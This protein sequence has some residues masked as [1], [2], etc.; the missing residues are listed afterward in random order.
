MNDTQREFLMWWLINYGTAPVDFYAIRDEYVGSSRILAVPPPDLFGDV[1]SK[2]FFKRR[3][4]FQVNVGLPQHIIK[5][6][7]K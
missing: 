5:K 4:V 2:L 7:Q 3:A 6:L 1:I